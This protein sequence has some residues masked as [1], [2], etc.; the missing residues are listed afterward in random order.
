MVNFRCERGCTAA[1]VCLVI[2]R[3]DLTFNSVDWVMQT[4]LH[5]VDG[6]HLIS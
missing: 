3:R 4:I 6:P 1:P 2:L 5:I